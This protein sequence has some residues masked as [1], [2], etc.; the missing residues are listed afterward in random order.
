MI[1][2]TILLPMIIL[3]GTV[4]LFAQNQIDAIRYSELF[5]Q[6]SAKAISM[7][8]SLSAVGADMSVLATNPA[9]LAVYKST[10]FEIT[11]GFVVSNTDGTINNANGISDNS[12]RSEQAYG[13]K[14]ANFGWTGV[15]K[16]D[17]DNWKQ[18]SFGIAYNRLNNFTQESVVNGKNTSGSIIDYF[19]YNANSPHSDDYGDRYS[20]YREALAWDAYLLEKDGDEYYNFVT[21][22]GTYGETQRKQILTKGGAGE[23]D[24]SFAANYRDIIYLGGTVGLQNI[25]FEQKTTYTENEFTDVFRESNSTPGDMIQVDPEELIFKQTLTT[26][27]SGFNFKFGMLFQP[28]KFVRFGA[29]IHSAT[30][31]DFADT[32]NTS[33]YARYPTADDNGDYDYYV[34]SDPGAFDWRLTTPFHANA[35]LAFILEPYQIGKF[36]TVPM[37]LS[38]DYEYTDYSNMRLKSYYSGDYDFD[39]ENEA[40]KN[41]FGTGHNLHAGAELN[42]GV[43]KVRGGYA[44]YSNPY[45]TADLFDNARFVYSGGIGLGSE[46]AYVDFAYSYTQTNETNYLYNATPNYPNNPIGSQYAA[47]PTANLV[48]TKHFAVITFG[49]RF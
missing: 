48:N 22:E 47:E 3:L 14:I 28:V 34:D 25:N 43:L 19:V 35:G 27:G 46:N 40:I 8:N 20:S 41:Q 9:G 24:F 36:Y 18:I 29:A 4:G 21:D 12:M 2:K 5:Y 26:K 45:E 31:L 7:G 30:F 38:F 39:G 6:S 44:L 13:F 10:H 42:F 32:Y 1:K 16:K 49:L 23:W 11:P 15:F 33:M 37:T 17:D